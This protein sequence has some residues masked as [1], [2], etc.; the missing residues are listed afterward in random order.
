M[1][2]LQSEIHLVDWVS[3]TKF[4]LDA[5][6]YQLELRKWTIWGVL[7]N[8]WIGVPITPRDIKRMWYSFLSEINIPIMNC[9][10]RGINIL[11]EESVYHIAD[12]WNHLTLFQEKPDKIYHINN[13]NFIS[14]YLFMNLTFLQ[15]VIE[16]TEK[17]KS[18]K[19]W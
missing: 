15:N 5:N 14:L 3:P 13:E 8:G 12:L 10:A 4:V 18:T 1:K 2:D 11:I 16:K 7:F 6:L 17:R 19:N 9:W